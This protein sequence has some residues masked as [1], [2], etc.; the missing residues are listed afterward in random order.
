[1]HFNDD[2]V[3]SWSWSWSLNPFVAT[4]CL[5]LIMQGS[6]TASTSTSTSGAIAAAD[7]I[8]TLPGQPEKVNFRQYAGYIPVDNQ[9]SRALFYYFV[10]A[11]SDSENRPLVLWLNGGIL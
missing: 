10:E 7:R 2:C 5:G 9:K 6:S 4:L 11:E 3:R 8:V 1:M